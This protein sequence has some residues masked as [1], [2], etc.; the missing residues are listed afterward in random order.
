M[1][2]PLFHPHPAGFRPAAS[3]LLHVF[4]STAEVRHG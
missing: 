3:F 4:G 2:R 1:R